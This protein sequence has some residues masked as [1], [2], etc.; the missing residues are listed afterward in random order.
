M[1]K[2]ERR[3]GGII[4]V[5]DAVCSAI[6]SNKNR[7]FEIEDTLSNLVY[8]YARLIDILTEKKILT[9]ENLERVFDDRTITQVILDN[10]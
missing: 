6:E 3:W 2:V 5:E 10:P 1:A 7:R 8:S 9:A 4:S